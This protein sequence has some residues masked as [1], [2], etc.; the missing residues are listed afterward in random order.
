MTHDNPWP[1]R[2]L[3]ETYALLT[4]PGAPFEM[5]EEVIRGVPMRTYVR[6]LPSLR[7]AFDTG[8]AWDDREHIVYRGERITFGAVRRA[9]AGL[10]KALGREFG[11]SKGDRVALAMRNLPEWV[12]TFWA[13]VATGAVIVPVNAWGTADEIA[14]AVRDSG[15]KVLVVDEE[16]FA[17]LG[18]A[19]ADLDLAGVIVARASPEKLR[20]ATAFE[21]LVGATRDYG[22]LPAVDLPDPQLEP[23]DDATIFYTSGTTGRPKGALGTHRN[24]TT[25]L[26][27]IGLRVA[28]AKLR[29]GETLEVAPPAA[30]LTTLLPVPL[31]HVTGCHSGITPAML[32][33]TRIVLMHKWV[34]ED[35][36]ALIERERVNTVVTVPAMT[37]QI[38]QSEV[39]DRYDLSSIA[40]ITYGGAP[41]PPELHGLVLE[42]FPGTFVANGFGM[43]ETSSVITSNSA[44]D[45]ALH[46]DSVG[47]AMPCNDFRVVDD[48]GAEVARGAAGEL[49]VKGPNIIKGYWRRTEETAAAIQDG[50]LRTGDIV[51]IDEEGFFYA[52]DRAK[53]VLI[54][55]GENVYCT[56]IE[57][58]A[59]RHPDVLEIAV[60]GVPHTVLGEE[61]GAVVR[62]VPGARVT[63]REL[64]AFVGGYLASFKA[65]AHIFRSEEP[66]PRNAAGKV[67]KR[68]LRDAVLAPGAAPIRGA[69]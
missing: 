56:E 39:L 48:T 22:G 45:F 51:R 6:A 34:V 49:L 21:G 69:D 35:A 58:V 1:R 59:M 4:A 67:L 52:L 38:V 31:F 53:D 54:R 17:R 12:V 14:Y 25:N 28:R 63:D 61:V 26:V 16:R 68:Q 46:P 20:G 11:V 64:Q 65:P 29:R 18:V 37:W 47:T 13:T 24:V 23:E 5:R 36:L 57:D 8:A 30:Q 2:T 50:W 32:S 3:H 43:T 7:A 27:N 33:G 10:G 42:R 62:L 19:L 41:A 55:G 40:T 15:A 60:I 66:L 44:E 9:A